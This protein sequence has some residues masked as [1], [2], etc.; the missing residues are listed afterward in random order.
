MRILTYDVENKDL[1][2]P[3]I[4]IQSCESI[5]DLIQNYM[6]FNP[7]VVV[8]SDNAASEVLE[9]FRSLKFQ[10]NIAVITQNN[11]TRNI[12]SW[13]SEGAAH[14]WSE[15]N[16]MD[17]LS[18]EFSQVKPLFSDEPVKEVSPLVDTFNSPSLVSYVIGV[19]GIYEGAGTTHTSIMIANYLSRATK[20]PV[21]IW[22]AG[23]KPCF[24][25]LDYLKNGQFHQSRPRFE[26]K[27]VTFFKETTSYQQLRSVANDFR[28]V[29]LDLGCLDQHKENTELFLDSDI[30]ILVGSGSEWR[31]KEIM[32]FCQLHNKVAQDRWRI[33]MPLARDEAVEEMGEALRGRPVFNIP[34]HSDPFDVQDDTDQ[35]LE[36]VLSPILPKRKRRRFMNFL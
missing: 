1:S 13:I 14:V 30:P 35:V 34:F 33:T 26:L 10:M 23:H 29:V 20:T 4:E 16:W 6:I 32:Q 28:F 5:N 31:M 8:V 12:R 19:G 17:E 2:M 15:L 7:S 27:N 24:H 18:E 3:H 36:G 21:A 25:F 9:K 11:D 22:E